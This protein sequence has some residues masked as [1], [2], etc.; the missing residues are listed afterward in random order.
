MT[1]E[2]KLIDKIIG[3][4]A[5]GDLEGTKSLI[6]EIDI[7]FSEDKHREIAKK[8]YQ[9][10]CFSGNLDMVHELI[11][12]TNG[13]EPTSFIKQ[14]FIALIDSKDKKYYPVMS[15]LINEPKLEAKRAPPEK[16]SEFYGTLNSYI[17]R[18][19]S[20]DDLPLMKVLLN[21]HEPEKRNKWIFNTNS[22]FREICT[23][24]DS[25]EVFK[26]L[27]TEPKFKNVLNPLMGLVGACRAEHKKALQFLIFD[28]KIIKNEEIETYLKKSG[29]K[30]ILKMLD[31]RE[32]NEELTNELQP[33]SE[34]SKRLKL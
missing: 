1:E 19:A 8:I 26:Y 14:I 25:I 20:D 13:P 2:K 11:Y 6:K 12:L 34:V 23:R 18:A 21:T 10:A 27:Y 9:A 30:D 3:T 33:N 22:L 15:Y 17:Q 24:S 28:Y 5:K 4:C 29:N 32:L 31:I 7:D 16:N